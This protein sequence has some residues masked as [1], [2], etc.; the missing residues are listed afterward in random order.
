MEL[1]EVL[2]QMQKKLLDKAAWAN[3]HTYMHSQITKQFSD[4]KH[5]GEARGVTWAPFKELWYTRSDGTEVSIF[6]G[7]K[8]ANGQGKVKAK[9]RSKNPE[10]KKRYNR[11]SNLVRST[12]MIF[13]ALLSHFRVSPTLIEMNT[14]VKYAGYQEKLRPWNFVTDQEADEITKMV[15]RQF[16]K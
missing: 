16:D 4:L 15:A 6:G 10:G 1:A 2:I 3:V 14:P 13:D 8:K 11:Q 5:G 9:L 12:G 7:I